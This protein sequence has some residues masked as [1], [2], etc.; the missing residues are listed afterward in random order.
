[1]SEMTVEEW[2]KFVLKKEEERD[3]FSKWVKEN[4]TTIILEAAAKKGLTSEEVVKLI[5]ESK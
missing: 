2:A 4:D 5:E 1:M 3:T